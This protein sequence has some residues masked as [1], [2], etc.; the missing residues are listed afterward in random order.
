[1]NIARFGDIHVYGDLTRCFK[2]F[3]YVIW[4]LYWSWV[5]RLLCIFM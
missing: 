2:S 1:M 4:F 5:S 3:R